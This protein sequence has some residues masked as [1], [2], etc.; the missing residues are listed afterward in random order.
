MDFKKS[1]PFFFALAMLTLATALLA[2]ERPDEDLCRDAYRSNRDYDVFCEVRERTLSQRDVIEIDARANGGITV[3][4]WGRNE[5]LV[6]ARV[7][8]RARS[9]RDA[10]DLAYSVD[11][12][13]GRVIEADGPR[14]RRNESWHVSYHVF[15]PYESNL[16][17]ISTNG[18]IH[19]ADVVGDIEFRVT[20]G[21]AHLEGVGGDVRGETTN[22]GLTITL[23][24][25]TW[26]GRGL[27]VETTNGGVTMYVPD[28]YNARLET[29]TVNG[30]IDLD[31]PITI[32][33]RMNRRRITTELG[34]GGPMIRATTT[35]GGVRI[36]RI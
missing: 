29:G 31:F 12:N 4:G 14:N 21:G 27:D 30:G 17:L 16:D 13:F 35:N 7:F 24:G 36:R 10:E 26:D 22:G 23:S 25:D 11:L 2:Q 15:A 18:G 33:G 20:N 8:A 6:R 19:I 5:I 3:T 32:Q 9:E 34:R 1:K 28:D